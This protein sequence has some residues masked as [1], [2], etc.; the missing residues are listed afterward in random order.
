MRAAEAPAHRRGAAI[1]ISAAIAGLIL[2]VMSA[3]YG[4]LAPAPAWAHQRASQDALLASGL[5]IPNLS[6]GEMAVVERYAPAIRRL[7]DSQV[8]TDP[9]FRR[10]AN[11]AALQRTYCLWGLAPGSLDDE[12]SPFNE[13]LHAYLATLRALLVHMQ[14]MPDGGRAAALASQMEQAMVESNAASNLCRNSADAFNTA[15][16]IVPQWGD[17]V[18]HPPTALAL[19]GLAIMAGAGALAVFG[20]GGARTGRG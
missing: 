12:A 8:R 3:A 7:A 6:H 4:L 20:P 1:R 18:S 11:F 13:C 9:T 19:M 2:G 15:Q 16:L 5:S 10:L 17:I 14:G